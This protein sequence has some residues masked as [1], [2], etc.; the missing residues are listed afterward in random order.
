MIRDFR[1][2]EQT[3]SRSLISRKKYLAEAFFRQVSDQIPGSKE[4][5]LSMNTT[6]QRLCMHVKQGHCAAEMFRPPAS[7]RPGN[8]P[9]GTLKDYDKFTREL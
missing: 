4:L 7:V 5:N 8:D 6:M 2:L 1:Y 3:Y 9:G